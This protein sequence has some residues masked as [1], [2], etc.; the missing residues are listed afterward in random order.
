MREGIRTVLAQSSVGT[1]ME[2][3]GEAGTGA[4]AL[5]LATK[6]QPDLVLLD[7]RLPDGYGFNVCREILTASPRS[8]V[9][10]LTAFSTDKF[11][12]E[13]ITSGAHGYLLK[14]LAPE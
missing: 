12:Y 4:E 2:I 1:Q 11:V 8:R 14:E 9:L 7:V 10:I 3:C 5:E 6:T 13:S